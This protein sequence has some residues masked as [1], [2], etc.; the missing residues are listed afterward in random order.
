M[1][2]T[3]V[4]KTAMAIKLDTKVDMNIITNDLLGPQPIQ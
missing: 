2:M 4:Q 3:D 1:K